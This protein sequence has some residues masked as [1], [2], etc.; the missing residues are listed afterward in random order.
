MPTL[1]RLPSLPN[2]EP[3]DLRV[4]GVFVLLTL[5]LVSPAVPPIFGR[6]GRQ[7]LAD[8]ASQ[9]QSEVR[10]ASRLIHDRDRVTELYFSSELADLGIKAEDTRGQIV[11]R[12]YEPAVAADRTRILA[13]A[14]EL[15]STAR[16]AA[17]AYDEPAVLTDAA[18]KLT[19]L[20]GELGALAG[21]P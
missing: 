2:A 1:P 21:S 13:A 11:E 14:D 19:K 7:D 10:E 20:D 15:S 6:T 9:L 18:T 17:D 3:L 12:P 8:I 4:A 16:D 5:A